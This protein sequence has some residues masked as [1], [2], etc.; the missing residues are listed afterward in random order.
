MEL[1]QLRYFIGVAEAGSF[2]A[3]ATKLRVSQPSIGQQV[4][5]LEEE[6]DVTL[7]QR[8]SRGIALTPAGVMFIDL[9]RDI[10][11][12]IEAARRIM[13]EQAAEPSGEIRIG[14]TAAASSHLAA[15]LVQQ[16]T[17][18]HPRIVL[19]VTEALSHH[20]VEQLEQDHL[21]MALAAIVEFPEGIRGEHLAQEDF[22][23]CI[24]VAHPLAHRPDVPMSEVLRYRLLLPPAS[25]SLRTQ[26]ETVAADLCLPVQVRVV[27]QSIGLLVDLVEHE[28]GVTIL[29]YSAV[30][31]QLDAGRLVALPIVE[32]RLTRTMTLLHSARRPMTR[33][34]IDV[35]DILRALVRVRME[36]PR[37]TWRAPGS[38]SPH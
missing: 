10:V 24:P 35:R 2:S 14:M 25:H 33:A 28:V 22:H 23:F 8:H 26:I 32:P 3:A 6:L 38:D 16:V 1:R 12:R 27:V 11:E 15:P 4:R 20:L 34:E 13:N 37:T 7:L 36:D 31:R 9:A 30:S 21:D 17:E 29:P 5:N 19:S 18:C